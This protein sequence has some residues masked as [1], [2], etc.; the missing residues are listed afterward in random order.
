MTEIRDVVSTCCRPSFALETDCGSR[1]PRRGRTPDIGR[2]GGPGQLRHQGR[3]LND[4]G[5]P[6]AGEHQ[7]Q[8]TIYDAK[9][10]GA[11]V[12]RNTKTVTVGESGFYTV[13]L[14]D[15]KPIT[16]DDL[17]V[18]TAWLSVRVD[19]GEPLEPRLKLETP[20]YAS[21]AARAEG[22]AE[23]AITDED[24]ASDFE[25]SSDQVSAVGWEDLEN[26][27]SDIADGDD[28]ALGQLSCSKDE[29]ALY[30]GSNWTCA[31]RLSYGSKDFA[32]TDQSCPQ[33]EVAAGIDTNG[34]LVC[35]D[36]AD[37]TYDGSDF[38]VSNQNCTAGNVVV[39]VDKNGDVLCTPQPSLGQNCKSGQIVAGIDKN[40]DIRCV[41]ET[42]PRVTGQNC[43]KG[44]VV[45]GIA[46]N[47]KVLCKKDE[48][49]TLTGGKNANVSGNSVNV[50]DQWV[51]ESGD[52]MAGKLDMGGNRIVNPGRNVA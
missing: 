39:G 22:V 24:L 27:P 18:G 6:A 29:I 28:D 21:I 46:Q 15:E 43:S 44:E 33:G 17:E 38:A 4:S 2:S 8:F 30:D 36:D 37:T 45:T 19:G 48:H 47:G 32:V 11:V 26:K 35:R 20:P 10:E 42:D 7:I 31:T 9:A 13:T 3:L 34:Q 5:E 40:G 12:W 41:P 14:G 16:P 23:G 49:S 52:K 50:P 1:G 25:V 51:D